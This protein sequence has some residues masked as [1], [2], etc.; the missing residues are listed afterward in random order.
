[1]AREYRPGE[2]AQRPGRGST[3][4][5]CSASTEDTVDQ[6]R[7]SVVLVSLPE[8][9]PD[10]T[11]QNVTRAIDRDL[12][13]PAGRMHVA[14][15]HP[16]PFLVRFEHSG[17]HDIVLAAGRAACR[18]TTLSLAPWTPAAGG[19]QRVWR[20]YCRIAVER[21]LLPCWTKEKL[22]DAVGWSYVIDRLERPS[23]T[24][25]NT[26]CVYAWA[27]VANP[28]AIP[29]SNDFSVL[30]LP[31]E[32]RGH[33][34]PSEGSPEAEGLQGPQFPILIHLD[35]TKDYAP[36]PAGS[37]AAWLRSERFQ[38]VSGIEDNASADGS[39]PR[40][41]SVHDR[42]R[43]A[44]RDDDDDEEARGSTQRRR[45][46][47]GGAGRSGDRRHAV[48]PRD[49]SDG[50]ASSHDVDH[51][52]ERADSQEESQA[53][54]SWLEPANGGLAELGMPVL[55][56]AQAAGG[57]QVAPAPP[58]AVPVPL[59]D[60]PDMLPLRS[61][62][63]DFWN[64][65]T[66][67][68]PLLLG[69]EVDQPLVTPGPRW[70]PLA[71]EDQLFWTA[72]KLT[73]VPWMGFS[74]DELGLALTYQDLEMPLLPAHEPLGTG[75]HAFGGAVTSLEPAPSPEAADS[76][77]EV[78]ADKMHSLEVDGNTTF[79]S[80]VFGML[81]ASIMGAPPVFAPFEHVVPVMVPTPPPASAPQPRRSSGRIAKG[82][83]GLTQEQKAHA[84]LAHQLEFID[85]P[86][87]FSSSVHAKYVARYKEPLGALTKKLG[88][89]TGIDS[90]ACIRLPDEDLAALAGETLG[91]F[92]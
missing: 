92:A 2:P 65:L 75:M 17:H 49:S 63:D 29:T 44:R 48:E 52:M 42:T 68:N 53:W 34:P 36:L 12:A 77:M 32:P 83:K 80:K 57:V 30:D 8:P 40:R 7:F 37:T 78:L 81:P 69:C 6:L 62:L 47:D 45:Q 61:D 76:A 10:I 3:F 24:W 31:P 5:F 39:R 4:T 13:I 64:E 74:P 66:R 54:S 60:E 89:V 79:L 91:S 19:H 27:W 73:V 43:P 88:R 18:G 28:D 41:A 87:K 56:V 70:A 51:G 58:A 33:A 50:P 15:H 67:V 1:M 85:A 16:E 20:F 82:P 26:S 35:T 90:A 38:W 21:V 14:K 72:D 25:A 9:R 71:V 46:D 23:L 59:H 22:Q 84:R 11:T 55:D 86:R